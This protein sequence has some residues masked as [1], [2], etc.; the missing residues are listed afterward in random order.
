MT[1]TGNKRGAAYT[2]PDQA[3][4][5]VRSGGC[6]ENKMLR[7]VRRRRLAVDKTKRSTRSNKQWKAGATPEC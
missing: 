4:E 2:G 7:L 1:G 3:H 5:N 6:T